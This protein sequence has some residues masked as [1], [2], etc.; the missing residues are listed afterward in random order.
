MEQAFLVK[1]PSDHEYAISPEHGAEWEFLW[2]R[3]D[4]LGAEELWQEWMAKLGPVAGFSPESPSIVL[5]RQLYRDASAKQTG[6][7]FDI[8]LR[9]YEWMLTLLRMLAGKEV[10]AADKIPAPYRQA[11]AIMDQH[12]AEE[13]TLTQIAGEVKLSPNHLCGIFPRYYG[14]TPMEYLR[15]RRIENA[16]RMLRENSLPIAQI[17]ARCGYSN[18]S[19][20]GKVFRKVLGLAPTS[21]REAG[22]EEIQDV[23]Q[24]LE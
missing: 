19:Y 20:F 6:D 8:S 18:T 1:V 10:A 14:A 16:A 13:L 3:F 12:F 7:R 22:P 2:V 23:L 4:G 5:L 15:N 11:A 17:A 21:F 24:L 9:I